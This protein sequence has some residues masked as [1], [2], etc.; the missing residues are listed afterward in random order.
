MINIGKKENGFKNKSTEAVCCF[1]AVIVYRQGSGR[2]D[3]PNRCVLLYRCME[4][5]AA[6]CNKMET[7]FIA[8]NSLT[9]TAMTSL[10][11]A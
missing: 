9:R 11:Y 5:R 2:T 6:P 8:R 4:T 7:N 10:N 3:T 1:F